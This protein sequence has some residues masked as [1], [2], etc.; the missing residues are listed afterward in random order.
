MP[1]IQEKDGKLICP[2]CSTNNVHLGYAQ[3]EQQ[4]FSTRITGN[5][6]VTLPIR[7]HD[8]GGSVVEIKLWCEN[9]HEFSYFFESEPGSVYI[10]SEQGSLNT[11]FDPPEMWIRER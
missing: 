2:T 6:V 10:E 7:I 8:K 4:K 11:N 5:R 1:V 3:G 9:D